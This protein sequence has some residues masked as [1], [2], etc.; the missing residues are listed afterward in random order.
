LLS[1][2]NTERVFD[3]EHPKSAAML[4]ELFGSYDQRSRS[5]PMTRISESSSD[6]NDWL[7]AADFCAGFALEIMMNAS[8]DR[9]R[10]LRRHFRKVIYNG[11]TR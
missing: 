3:N 1:E 8:D 11:A 4:N 10:E 9:K 7:Q 2:F 5:V 6:S